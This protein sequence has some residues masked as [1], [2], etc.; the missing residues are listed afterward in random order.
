MHTHA[1][2]TVPPH[3]GSK[4]LE[5]VARWTLT[6]NHKESGTLS[7]WFSFARFFVAG[8]MARVIRG[9]L[10]EPGIQ[11][12][13]G[14]DSIRAFVAMFQGAKVD[15]AA[16]WADTIEVHGRTALYWGTYFE[17]LEFPGQP[18]SEQHG[19]FIA[20]WVRQDDGRW[21]ISRLYRIPLPGTREGTAVTRP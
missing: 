3:S 14:P 20:E 2:H 19:K 18:I 1:E 12:I 6:T 5:F 10:F 13:V 9:E 21:L 16:V 11:P 8:A 7:L 17:R 4:F 15:S